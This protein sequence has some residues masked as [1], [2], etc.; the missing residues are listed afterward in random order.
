MILS[1]WYSNPGETWTLPLP[2]LHWLSTS[3]GFL[4]V[5][6]S[7]VLISANDAWSSIYAYIVGAYLMGVVSAF[8]LGNLMAREGGDARRNAGPTRDSQPPA[9]RP[10]SMDN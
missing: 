4:G 3:G 7:G 10:N 6:P 2:S 9:A 1:G 8:V 5:N